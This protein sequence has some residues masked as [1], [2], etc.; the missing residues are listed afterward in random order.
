LWIGSFPLNREFVW[1]N[2]NCFVLQGIRNR[3]SVVGWITYFPY[4]F[5][6]VGSKMMEWGGRGGGV[7]I[8]A[9]RFLLC[10]FTNWIK[11]RRNGNGSFAYFL[12]GIF[13]RFSTKFG[14]DHQWWKVISIGLI[15]N[16]FVHAAK[17]ETVPRDAV[18]RWSRLCCAVLP[19]LVCP[20][21][22]EI[23]QEPAKLNHLLVFL[24]TVN[25]GPKPVIETQGTSWENERQWG[26]SAEVYDLIT[27]RGTTVLT[28]S[29]VWTLRNWTY[30]D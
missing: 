8:L 21:R 17:H 15:K 9:S 27:S 1:E 28:F 30:N 4:H 14:I 24:L 23:A 18:V 10:V 26:K 3:T 7:Y 11:R 13:R 25:V 5:F 12:S 29:P 20:L 22:E 19:S 2:G 16:A 6:L